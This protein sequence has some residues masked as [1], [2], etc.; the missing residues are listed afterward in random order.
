MNSSEQQEFRAK[1]QGS[2]AAAA[3]AKYWQNV[4]GVPAGVMLQCSCCKL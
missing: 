3:V 4:A 2:E 1:A